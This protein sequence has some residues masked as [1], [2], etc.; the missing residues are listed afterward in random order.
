M[1]TLILISIL[2]SSPFFWAQSKEYYT[3]EEVKLY[4]FLN[5]DISNT[6]E[7]ND[8]IIALANESATDLLRKEQN[9]YFK[10]Y[11]QG[12]LASISMRGTSASHTAVFWNGVPINSRLNGQTDFNNLYLKSFDRIHI[13]KGGGSSLLGSAAIGGSINLSTPQEYN[14]GFSARVSS[15]IGSYDS[16]LN[17]VSVVNSTDSS[18]TSSG[19]ETYF[20]E[21]DYTYPGLKQKNENGQIET[22]NLFFSHRSKLNESQH[23]YINSLFNISDKN[24]SGTLYAPSTANLKNNISNIMLGWFMKRQNLSLEL[25]TAGIREHYNYLTNKDDLNSSL[26]NKSD[27]LF[28]QLDFTYTLNMKHRILL[29]GSYEYTH[30]YGESIFDKAY[31]KTA[32]YL[33][34][35]HTGTN[36]IQYNIGIRKESTTAFEIPWVFSLET[37]YRVSD[38]WNLKASLSNNF[39]IPTINDL[40]WK[41]GGNPDLK[42][43]HTYN[44]D[45]GIQ[46][47][48]SKHSFNLNTFLI[49]GKDVIQW[50]PTVQQIWRPFNVKE[51]QSMG[52]E[53]QDDHLFNIGS[54]RVNWRNQY[55]YTRAIDKFTGNIAIY[56]PQHYFHMDF[57]LTYGTLKWGIQQ[58]YSGKVFYTT[59]ESAYNEAYNL[60]NTYLNKRIYQGKFQVCFQVNNLLNKYYE[61]IAS[62][63]MPN[64]NYQ[65]KLTLNF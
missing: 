58:A 32:F 53:W 1:R 47:K 60:T 33:L 19:I 17:E 29:G 37:K 52:I 16:F 21:N 15:Q 59:D 63:P 65:L 44:A 46:Y 36:V 28:Q 41:Q 31:H 9:I 54:I 30:G 26:Q 10:E 13:K 5:N 40:Y 49:E 7:L 34:Y 27:V 23:L 4:G 50:Q 43:E 57:G 61:I 14:K 20:S 62:R 64:R 42:A 51:F 3:L 35:A 39:R 6:S 11:G 18:I 56:V 12:M 38:K 48:I 24:N 25:K 8:S 2:L 55:T 22:Y 45:F